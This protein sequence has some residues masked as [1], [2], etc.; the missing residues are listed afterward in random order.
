MLFLGNAALAEDNF[1]LSLANLL[2]H[3][4]HC[5]LVAIDLQ[6]NKQ[7]AASGNSLKEQQAPG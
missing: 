3:N 6:E 5:Q 7:I 1:K 2:P 4:A